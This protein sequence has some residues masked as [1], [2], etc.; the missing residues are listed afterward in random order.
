MKQSIVTTCIIPEQIEE[1][2]TGGRDLYTGNVH[3]NHNIQNYCMSQ[4][5]WLNL[6]SNLLYKVGQDFSNIVYKQY[7]WPMQ[8]EQL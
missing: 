3:L 2:S 7:W 5:S 8:D 4:K 6:Y 1:E